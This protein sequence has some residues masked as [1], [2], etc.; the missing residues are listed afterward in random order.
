LDKYFSSQSY[1][2]QK[3][4]EKSM[5]LAHL[6][7]LHLG[8]QV[9]GFSMMEDQRYILDEIIGIIRQE[10]VDAVLI[11]GDV[12]DKPVP[13]AEAVTIFDEF[14]DRLS[15]MGKEVLIISGNHDSAER[16]AFGSRLLGRSG[17]HISPV[18][19]G[20]IEPVTLNDDYGAVKFWLLPFLKPVHVRRFI[21]NEEEREQVKSYDQAL[22]YVIDRLPVDPEKRNVLLTH[23]FITGAKTSDSEELSVGGIDHVEAGHFGIF[24]YTALGHIHRPQKAKGE[25]IRYSGSPLKY[26]FSEA[27]AEKSLPIV[28][29]REKGNI[30]LQLHPLL[31]LH[32]LKEIRGSYEDVTKKSF[33]E[34]QNL[35]SCYVRVTLTDEDDIPDALG[36]LR[37]I[38]PLLMRLDYDNSRT[39]SQQEI[40]GEEAAEKKSPEDLLEDFYRLQNNQDMNKRQK[41]FAEQCIGKVFGGEE[42]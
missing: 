10:E 15:E 34:Q 36:K 6:A 13:P 14:L 8:K 26:S 17:V 11:S 3:E 28:E 40:A 2:H 31:P 16:L 32:D 37:L 12:Y 4:T 27:D 29:L 7:D 42:A 22:A 5:K 23:Q 38:Y 41:K 30:S 35:Q 1:S 19:N 25:F 33:Y 39:R 20:T 9:N 24:D 18:Y 21:E